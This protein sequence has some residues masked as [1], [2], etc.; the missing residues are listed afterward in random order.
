MATLLLANVASAQTT[1]VKNNTNCDMYYA[2]SSY[3]STT[4]Q[5]AGT[6]QIPIGA[7]SASTYTPPAGYEV[8]WVRVYS[9]TAPSGTTATVGPT[10]TTATVTTC[11]PTP[12]DVEWTSASVTTATVSITP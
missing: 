1:T 5:W 4:N 7:T 2:V 9:F 8:V 6:G 11:D 12:A 10:S 3:N